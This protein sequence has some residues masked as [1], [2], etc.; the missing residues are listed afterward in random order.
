MLK[1]ILTRM[2]FFFFQGNIA[3]GQITI[4][5]VNVGI[6]ALFMLIGFGLGRL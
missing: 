2:V 3:D 5:L 6:A 1:N 4:N